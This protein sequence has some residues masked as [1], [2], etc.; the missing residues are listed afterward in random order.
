MQFSSCRWCSNIFI[1]AFTV[2][3]TREDAP[4]IF[5]F[6]FHKVRALAPFLPPMSCNGNSYMQYVGILHAVFFNHNP[7][8]TGA[9]SLTSSVVMIAPLVSSNSSIQHYVIKFVRGFQQVDCIL[10]VLRFPPP[11]KLTAMI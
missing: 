10:Q 2:S 7:N 11:I 8:N 5:Y 4:H 9:G 6:C 3:D 1:L